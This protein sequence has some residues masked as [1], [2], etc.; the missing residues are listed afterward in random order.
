VRSRLPVKLVYHEKYS[1]KSEALKR[2]MQIKGWERDKKIKML[3]LDIRD[4]NFF[5]EL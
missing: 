1:S 4:T 2:E 3:K 5:R